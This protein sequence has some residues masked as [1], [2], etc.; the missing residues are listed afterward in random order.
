M[1]NSRLMERNYIHI[2]FYQKTFV[3]FENCLFGLKDSVKYFAFLI[4]VRFRRI[5]VFGSFYIALHNPCAKTEYSPRKTMNRKNH[6]FP[7][8]VKALSS[9]FSVYGQTRCFEQSFT[10]TFFFGSDS[11]CVFLNR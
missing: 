1:F 10:V 4:N 9:F 8:T 5:Q 11:E 3:S 6:S 7:E 2:T